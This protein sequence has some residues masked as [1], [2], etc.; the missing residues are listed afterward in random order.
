MV[1]VGRESSVIEMP[2][3]ARQYVVYRRVHGRRRDCPRHCSGC[4]SRL[5]VCLSVCVCVSVCVCMQ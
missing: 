1:V 4:S 2:T 3:S 5:Y